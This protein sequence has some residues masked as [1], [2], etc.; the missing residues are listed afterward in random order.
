LLANAERLQRLSSECYALLYDSDQSV[1]AGLGGVWRRLAEL[2]ELDGRFGPYAAA[3]DAI[4]PQLE[5]MA[6]FLRSYASDA[7]L[8]PERL[9]QV[10]ERLSSLER[11]KRKHGPSLDEVLSRLQDYRAELAGL[12]RS[13]DLAA[14]LE[15]SLSKARQQFLAAATRLSAARRE[16]ARRF[17]DALETELGHLAMG[18]TRFDVRFRDGE[19]SEAQWTERGIDEAE[20][21]VSTNPG[22]ELRPLSRIA[23][24]G[25][26]SRIM[27]ALKTLASIDMPGKTLVFDEVDA[28]IGGQVAGTVGSRLRRLGDDFQVLCITHLPQIAAFGD[29]HFAITKESDGGRS[30]TH[31]ARLDREKRIEELARMMTGDGQSTG[32]RAT[33]GELLALC[34]G[35]ESENKTKGESERAKAKARPSAASASRLSGGASTYLHSST[36]R[37]STLS[38]PSVAR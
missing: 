24:G 32:T 2:Q 31:I 26:L 29:T 9:D 8:S 36:Q 15:A 21:Y 3:R 1:L 35:G 22:E 20:F 10:E 6:S 18:G 4:K 33:A 13:E 30:V 19:A 11:L 27:L 7:D 12:E 14:E 25:E 23:S 34:S 5:D 38:R 37:A 17:A 28:G 16:A